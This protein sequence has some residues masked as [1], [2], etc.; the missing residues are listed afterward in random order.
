MFNHL[1]PLSAETLTN[2]LD[3]KRD[4]GLW[5]GVLTVSAVSILPNCGEV[6]NVLRPWAT[7]SPTVAG[8]VSP[9]AVSRALT[10]SVPLLVG[11][12]TPQPRVSSQSILKRIHVVSIPYALMKANPLSWIQKVCVYKGNRGTSSVCAPFLRRVF[13]LVFGD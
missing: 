11:P 2:V 13:E 10:L 3:F 8:G 6:A 12:P 9:C 5:H 4:A 7:P 1:C